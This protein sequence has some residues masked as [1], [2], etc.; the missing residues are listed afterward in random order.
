MC[1]VLLSEKMSDRIKMIFGNKA[2]PEFNAAAYDH[3]MVIVSLLLV[4]SMFG[5]FRYYFVRNPWQAWN[6]R[7][8]RKRYEQWVKFYRKSCRVC[9]TQECATP[10]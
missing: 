2:S 1:A 10:V 9:N 4:I 7:R 5:S 8:Q 3:F 6:W